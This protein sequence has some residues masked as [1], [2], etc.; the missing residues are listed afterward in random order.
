MEYPEGATPLDPDEMDGLKF[1]HV[2][3]RGELDHL[4]Q[5]NIQD[6]LRWLTR[7]KGKDILNDQFARKLHSQLFG[8]VWKWAGQFRNTEKNI[9]VDPIQISIKLRE[10]L[11][12][13]QYWVEHETYDPKEA[14]VR[15]HH[16]L[17]YI[18]LF[19][20]GNGRHARFYAD[21]LLEKVYGT[22]WIDWSGGYDLQQMNERRNQYINALRAADAGNYD[23]LFEFAGVEQ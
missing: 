2:T 21:A 6:G 7:H 22:G 16:R 17:V 5:A 10:L 1:S 13:V 9:G 20:N 15:F 23:P 11:D 3:T 12:D 18:H 19:P 8:A 4:E 14:A